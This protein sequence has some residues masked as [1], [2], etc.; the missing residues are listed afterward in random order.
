MYES[1]FPARSKRPGSVRKIFPAAIYLRT[2][3]WLRACGSNYRSTGPW[4]GEVMC[5]VVSPP[6][7]TISTHSRAN[8]MILSNAAC[9]RVYTTPPTLYPSTA[10]GTSRGCVCFARLSSICP[11]LVYVFVIIIFFFCRFLR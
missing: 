10:E 1:G 9:R 6:R 3:Q 8:K 5:F 4:G 2:A 11:V 7:N